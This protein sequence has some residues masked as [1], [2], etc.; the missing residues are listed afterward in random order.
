M[1]DKDG[2]RPNVG[3]IL[4]NPGGQVLW[5]HRC[6]GDGWQFPQG[7][8][9]PKETIEQA[10]Y[11]ELYEEVG[12]VERHVRV[13]GRTRNWLRYDIPGEYRRAVGSRRFRGQKQVWFLLRLIGEDS[14]MRLDL[15]RSPEFDAWRWVEYWSPLQSIVAFKRDVY[16]TALT[17]L[18]PLLL[19]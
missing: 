13:C 9:K 7:G 2:Y 15:S 16:L 4:A 19:R 1:I 12:L 5:A 3:I 6:R 11:R 17:E 14:D 8:V 18:A 10:L